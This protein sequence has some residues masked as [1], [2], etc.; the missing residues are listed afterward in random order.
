LSKVT[1]WNYSGAK[2]MRTGAPIHT[3]KNLLNIRESW[4]PKTIGSRSAC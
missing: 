1:G 3:T 4:Q 2:L